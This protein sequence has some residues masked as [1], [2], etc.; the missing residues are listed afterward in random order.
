MNTANKLLNEIGLN[1]ADA[2]R[3]MLESSEAL[4][5]LS[6]GKPR[7]EMITLLRRAMQLGAKAVQ[8]AEQTVSLEEAA[9]ASV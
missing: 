8:D 1:A 5:E 9:W 7:P 6:R 3:L 2:A 4:G